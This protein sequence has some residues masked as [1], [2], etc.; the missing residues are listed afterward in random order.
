MIS[1]LAQ[2]YNTYTVNLEKFFS[3]YS[4]IGRKI[5]DFLHIIF[6]NAFNMLLYATILIS[7]LYLI[8]SVYIIFKK[9]KK[10]IHRYEG[11]LPSVTV[12]IPTYN[13]LVAIRCAKACLSFDYPK[14]KYEIII[15]D[16]SNRPE[17][18]EK[19]A[20]FAKEHDLIRIIKRANNYGYK[21]GNLNSMLKH[22]K[23]E[24]LAIFDSDFVPQEDFLRRIVQPFM[25]DDK[26]AGVQARWRLMNANQ[27]IIT[28]LG[29]TIVAICHYIAL[30]FI[31][32]RK[33]IALLC[34]SAEAV[35]KKTL[36]ELGGWD[37][38]NLTEDIEFALRLLKNGYKI[39]YLED[40]ECEGEVPY[41][42]KDLYRQQMRWGYGVISS[43]KK[44]FASIIKSKH[45][46]MSD[47]LH[48][49]VI[50]LSGYLITAL[51][52]CLFLVGT[53]SFITHAPEPINWGEFTYNFARN[54][55]LT[56]GFI[57]A[58]IVALARARKIKLILPMIASSFS[59]GL[60]DIYHVNVGIL[61]AL[62]RMPMEWY[63]LNK[64]G[65]ELAE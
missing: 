53:L 50:F 12:Q 43:W 38:G 37:N 8:I 20:E 10:A 65:N 26:I 27:N 13:E 3:W 22:S 15:G 9:Q 21:P 52:L 17:I 44:H 54:V 47:K 1:L 36:I 32:G 16:D 24:I 19:I 11:D 4:I 62:A 23:G 39:E 58:G 60:V 57:F 30:S 5:L 34:G 2:Y 64:H 48:M 49:Q 42:I 41:T 28:A 33:R 63:M 59:Y 40:L 55:V 7:L 51:M 35:R 6:E 46:S 56:S 31:Y 25:N 14:D 45:L 61:K 18:S 29:T